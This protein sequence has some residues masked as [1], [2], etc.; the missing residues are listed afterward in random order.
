MGVLVDAIPKLCRT[1]RDVLS[2]FQGAGLDRS[3]LGKYE[4]L[5][6]ADSAN[7]RKPL[8]TREI[9]LHVNELGDAGLRTRREIL[10]RIAEFDDFS[11]CW[12]D[13]Q[14]AARGY[15]SQ[16]RDLVN[17]KDSFTRMK[18][19]EE[20]ERRKRLDEIEKRNVA[21]RTQREKFADAKQALYNVFREHDPQKRGK[22]LEGAVNKLFDAA[23][24]LVCDAFTLVGRSGQGVIEQ[25]DG[26]IELEGHIY[27]VELKWW[28]KPLGPGE[29][30]QH[31]VRIFSRGGGCRG[32]IIS[33]SGFTDAAVETCRNSMSAGALVILSELQE[34][35]QL[36]ERDGDIKKWLKAKIAAAVVHRNPLHKPPLP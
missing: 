6:H 13:D 27:L 22:A 2:F 19:A 23:E 31:Q 11:V 3:V 16:I 35:I 29:I 28:N 4:T 21:M 18:L 33:Y 8:V 20:A 32:L 9:L 7:F 1:K 15:V 30:G 14:A 24:I 26:L 5:L 34:I 10:K 25:I 17:V 36:L 12:P